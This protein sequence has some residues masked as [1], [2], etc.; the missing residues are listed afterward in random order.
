MAPTKPSPSPGPMKIAIIG[1][2][3]GG[4][5]LARLLLRGSIPVTIFE[6][7]VSI[8]ARNQGGTLDL[9]DD[10]G[11][12]ALKEAGLYGEFLKLDR[13]HGDALQVCDKRM[14][15]YMKLNSHKEG[16]SRFSQRRPEIDRIELR[17][18]LLDSLPEGT[19]RWGCR[20]LSVGPGDL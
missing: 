11:L 2:G 16:C 8:D 17:R 14:L 19:I 5:I 6:A 9:H 10:T 7:E 12:A 3:P 13:F 1:A 18:L 4:C 20:L 15:C